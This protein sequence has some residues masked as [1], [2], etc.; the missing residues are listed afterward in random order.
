VQTEAITSHVLLTG[1][2]WFRATVPMAKAAAREIA[3][4]ELGEWI[5]TIKSRK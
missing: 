2:P 4:Q 1:S 5:H 3:A